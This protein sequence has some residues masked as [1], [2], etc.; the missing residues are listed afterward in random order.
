[1]NFMFPNIRD[2]IFYRLNTKITAAIVLSLITVLGT[3]T[4]FMEKIEKDDALGRAKETGAF[5]T[6]TILR[7]LEY[8]M[9]KNDREA[10]DFYLEG[11][12]GAQEIRSASVT[13]N[14]GSIAFSTNK[15]A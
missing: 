14:D 6:S 15:K 11:L 10:I 5:I 4:F 9:L 7:N 12:T 3:S 8:H 13:G 1:M 2:K